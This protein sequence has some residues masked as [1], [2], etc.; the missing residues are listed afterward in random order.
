LE[1]LLRLSPLRFRLAE[2]LARLRK[3]DV[4]ELYGDSSRLR[5]ATGWE[6]KI[7]QGEMLK[8]IL[9]DARRRQGAADSS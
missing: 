1:G 9:V 4:A 2:D 8:S 6:P 5:A 3:K 7:G